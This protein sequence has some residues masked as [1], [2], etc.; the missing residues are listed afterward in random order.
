[1]M[2]NKPFFYLNNSFRFSF[3]TLCIVF[4]V[5]ILTVSCAATKKLDFSRNTSEA[6][7]YKSAQEYIGRRR[8]ADAI[9]ELQAMEKQ[10]PFGEYS[11]AAQ[12]SLIYAHYGDEEP[13]SARATANRFIRL[14]PQHRNVDY[15]YY[16]KGLIDFPKA[17][18]AFQRIFYVDL[19]K[20]DIN[21]ARASFNQFSLLTKRFPK[22]EYT[23]DALKRMEF[24]RNLLARHEI[25]V[26]NYYFERKAYLAAANRGRYVVE[27]FQRT[28]AI[29]DAL[30]VMAQ[31]Y[32]LMNLHDLSKD[33]VDTLRAN[34]PDYPAL[35]K[36]GEFDFGY[37]SR[38]FSSFLNKITLGLLGS[39]RPPGFNTEAYY[40]QKAQ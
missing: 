11:K 8:Y 37:S 7:L 3:R 16:M 18:T 6:E 10:Y 32:H 21:E 34:F 23:P 24:L 39:S 29:P 1:M 15:A 12:L 14:H 40:N 36:E 27:N 26:A 17:K 19:S 22:S 4:F 13:E 30:A 20:R 31:G 9:S 38:T 28:P 5:S 2:C 33:S 35:T 25:H